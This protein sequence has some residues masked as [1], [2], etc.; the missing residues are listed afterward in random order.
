MSGT[1]TLTQPGR[2]F[3]LN[4][5]CDVSK[6]GAAAQV[7]AVWP[8]GLELLFCG[9]HGRAQMPALKSQNPEVQIVEKDNQTV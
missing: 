4:D 2:K 7:A 5:R 1:A 3:T 8:G 6:C 9:H